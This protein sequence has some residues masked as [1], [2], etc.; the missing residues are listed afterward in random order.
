MSNFTYAAGAVQG[1]RGDHLRYPD[2]PRFIGAALYENCK[3]GL[4]NG[5]FYIWGF[6][7]MEIRYTE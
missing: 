6:F 1:K 5:R 7:T 3:G 2:R 4:R